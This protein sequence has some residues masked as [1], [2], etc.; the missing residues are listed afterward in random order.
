VP[1]GLWLLGGAFVG[2]SL[3]KGMCVFVVFC[4]WA[5]TQLYQVAAAV[6]L[7]QLSCQGLQGMHV[8]QVG[9]GCHW[10]L[11]ACHC[12]S[13]GGELAVLPCVA[14][15]AAGGKGGWM[16][17]WTWPSLHVQGS[18]GCGVFQQVGLARGGACWVC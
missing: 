2:P 7:L 13:V 6:Q 1:G 12:C 8:K 4:T 16:Y 3:C 15:F 18:S 17:V 9:G 11:Q 14:V 5:R 10:R